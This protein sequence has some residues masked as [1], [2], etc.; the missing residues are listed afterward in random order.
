MKNNAYIFILTF[1]ALIS[2]AHDSELSTEPLPRSDSSLRACQLLKEAFPELVAFPGI[3][4][5]PLSGNKK[6]H[7]LHGS[8]CRWKGS[9]QYEVDIEHWDSTTTQN[10]TCS[11]EPETADDV[12]RIVSRSLTLRI[13]QQPI[14]RTSSVIIAENCWKK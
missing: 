10:A 9:E 12:S 6:R 2:S 14:Q 3:V 11:V 5:I 4:H 7:R 1:F 8:C 13:P